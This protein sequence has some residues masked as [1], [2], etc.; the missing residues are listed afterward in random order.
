MLLW[1]RLVTQTQCCK[2]PTEPNRAFWKTLWKNLASH[3]LMTEIQNHGPINTHGRFNIMRP[4]N[5]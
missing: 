1:L 4:S 3:P 2:D 5:H